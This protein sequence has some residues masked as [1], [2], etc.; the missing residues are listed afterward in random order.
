MVKTVNKVKLGRSR[1]SNQSLSLGGAEAGTQAGTD[2]EAINV[3]LTG[4]LQD[5]LPRGGTTHSGLTGPSQVNY[6]S[7][8]CPAVLLTGQTEGDIFSV[9][10]PLST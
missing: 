6:Q 9:D 3:W 10:S 2:T 8:K 7:R 5:P 4:L 1:L